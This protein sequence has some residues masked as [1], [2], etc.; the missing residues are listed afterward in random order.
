MPKF[1]KT[2]A[3]LTLIVAVL[4]VFV[5]SV[6]SILLP[7]VLAFVLAYFLQPAVDKLQCRKISRTLATSVVVVFFCWAVVMLFLILVPLLQAQ[8]MTLMVKVP[9]LAQMVWDSVRDVIVYAQENIAQERLEQLSGS[10]SQMVVNVFNSIGSGLL[11]MLSGGAVVFNV[12][13]LLLITPVVLFYVL[14]DWKGV[15]EKMTALIPDKQKKRVLGVMDEINR[16][17]SGFIRGQATVCLALGVFYALG[18]SLAGLDFG[19]LVGFLSGVLSFVPY[20]GFLTGVILSVLLGLVQHGGWSL[21]IGLLIVFSLGQLLES[22]VLTPKLVGDKVGLHPVWVIFALLAG[23]VLLGF[24][25]VLI[26]V[27]VAAVIGVFVRHIVEWYQ[28]TSV[29]KGTK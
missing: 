13:S 12:I 27:P 21:W 6:Q 16:I 7:F 19:L 22:Y 15:E 11:K 28:N 26:A 14:R 2:I 10:V 20:F 29:Y 25:G 1:N 18:L 23:G 8:I 4:A 17:L 24:L 3:W 9:A 5:V